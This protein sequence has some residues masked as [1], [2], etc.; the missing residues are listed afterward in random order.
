MFP[1]RGKIANHQV[2]EMIANIP[3]NLYGMV[4]IDVETNPSP[5]CSWNG[6]S[7]ESNC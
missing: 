4:W 6:Y 7:G 2:D 3:G 1:C 5:G